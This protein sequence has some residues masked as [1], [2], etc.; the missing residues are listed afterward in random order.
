MESEKHDI[1]VG[2]FVAVGLGITM[3]LILMLGGDK[4]IFHSYYEVRVRFDSVDGLSKGSKVSL[5][6][7]QVGNVKKITI[8]PDGIS[9]EAHLEVDEQ[10]KWR[11][12]EGSMAQIKSQGALGDKFIFKNP[13]L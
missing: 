9:I 13:D 10:Y 11:L 4:M 3:V 8:L 1:K 2:L 7:I 6:G 5:S 12:T